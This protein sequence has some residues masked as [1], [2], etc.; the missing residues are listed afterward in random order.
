MRTENRTA[1]ITGASRGFGL[2]LA[3]R[4][5]KKGWQLLL[6]A[7]DPSRLLAVRRRLEQYSIVIAVSGDIKD[8]IHLLEIAGILESRGLQPE[9]VVNNASELGIS[10]LKPLLE[11]PV[12]DLHRVFHTNM[13]APVSLLQK[14]FPYLK[15]GARIINVTSDAGSEA[16]ETWGAYG[17]S[18]AGLDH[19]TSVLG[20][21]N[22]GYKFYAFDPGDMRTDMQQAAFPGEDIS[23]RPLPGDYAVPAIMQLIEGSKPGG[24][25]TVQTLVKQLL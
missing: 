14:I 21:E 25:Y 20:R 1:L 23:D 6:T 4:L 18:K 7:R 10:P 17:G 22:P 2:S 19:M 5:A 11:H 16:Y 13:I 9:L 12:E 3:E 24:R 8:E 15:E